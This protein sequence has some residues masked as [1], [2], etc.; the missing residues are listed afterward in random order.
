MRHRLAI[1]DN[2]KHWQVFSD[3]QE[4]KRFLENIDEFLPFLLI[5]RMK[6]MR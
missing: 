1:P 3:D 5:K 6:M 2:V 4:M